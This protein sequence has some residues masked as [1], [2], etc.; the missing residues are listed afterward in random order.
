MADDITHYDAIEGYVSPP[1]CRAGESV[2]LCA[3]TTSDRFDATVHRWGG[4]RLLMWSASGVAG[5]Q[6]ATPTD[7]DAAGCGWGPLLEIPTDETWPSGFYLV[8]M[9]AHGAAADR[10]VS[11][12]GFV[13]RAG[14]QR[15]RALFV[16]ATNTWNAYNNW[17]GRSLYTGGHEV[18]FARPWGRGMLVRPEVDRED[19]KSPPRRPGEQ[20]D[21]DGDMYQ[22]SATST[23]FRATWDRPGGSPTTAASPS[24]P[25][26]PG[27][28]STTR[29][30]AISI[31]ST[32][33]PTA[34]N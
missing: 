8:T 34:T 28:S 22:K 27:T 26:A 11:Y 5:R 12:S 16:L 4:E 9:T 20:P 30:R 19:R 3:S 29:S 33:S 25:S 21:V 1:S 13:V 7:A 24:G 14:R 18:S 32:A 10:D 2:A 17:G 6:H 23:A 31:S 15:R